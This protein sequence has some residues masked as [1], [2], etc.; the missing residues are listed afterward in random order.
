MIT[1]ANTAIYHWNESLGDDALGIY[2]PLVTTD[3]QKF[4]LL[5]L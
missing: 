4:M 2:I 3:S 5:Q 1:F